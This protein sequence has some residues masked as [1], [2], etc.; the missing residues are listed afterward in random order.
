MGDSCE[1]GIN[2]GATPGAVMHSEPTARA[3]GRPPAWNRFQSIARRL[4]RGC[5]IF[6]FR[7]RVGYVHED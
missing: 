5:P 7:R 1:S 2:P 4:V 3:V 6:R